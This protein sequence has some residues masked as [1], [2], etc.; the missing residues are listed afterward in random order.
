MDVPEL[1]A[2]EDLFALVVDEHD[3]PSGVQPI[4][5]RLDEASESLEPAGVLSVLETCKDPGTVISAVFL[6]VRSAKRKGGVPAK[7]EKALLHLIS[8]NRTSEVQVG[9]VPQVFDL[10]A[11]A[12]GAYFDL[13]RLRPRDIVAVLGVLGASLV[14]P[15]RADLTAA[16][17]HQFN[18]LFQ[19]DA[20]YNGAAEQV[21]ELL[22]EAVEDGALS[23]A[24]RVR[25][26]EA[27][28]CGARFSP[29]G[30]HPHPLADKVFG[31]QR[32]RA[33]LA[34]VAALEKGPSKPELREYVLCNLAAIRPEAIASL[35]EKGIIPLSILP[36]PQDLVDFETL[37]PDPAKASRICLRLKPE[38]IVDALNSPKDDDPGLFAA[39]LLAPC[40]VRRTAWQALANRLAELSASDSRLELRSGDKTAVFQVGKEAA[41]SLLSLLRGVPVEDEPPALE[42]LFKG[43]EACL[44]R[45]VNASW[46]PLGP[47]MEYLFELNSRETETKG[48]LKKTMAEILTTAN[49]P[50]KARIAAFCTYRNLDPEADTWA[51]EAMAN[52]K[53]DP[54]FAGLLRS[55]TH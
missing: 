4:E 33:A 21:A 14:N 37:A 29:A 32:L 39:V 27:I 22:A 3:N 5:S 1:P 15:R 24:T 12:F 50:A 43:L 30:R 11:C 53:E 2:L 42:W 7:F 40:F 16:A 13:I 6:A 28:V 54:E 51:A 47:V 49:R 41:L 38:Q 44:S 20:R 46:A 26:Y 52:P 55:L 35:Q 18:L 34:L 8:D 10:A 48:R 17:V 23:S 31:K 45:G 9:G 19:D 36:A 25:A